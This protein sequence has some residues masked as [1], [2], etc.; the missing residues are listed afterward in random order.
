MAPRAKTA[1]GVGEAIGGKVSF[2]EARISS[3]RIGKHIIRRP[4]VSIYRGAAGADAGADAGVIGGEIF[5]RFTVTL[6]YQSGKR[7]L[8]PNAH[9]NEPY[10]V[11]MSG[12]EL[13]VKANDFKAILIKDVRAGTPAAAAGLREGDVVVSID[14][15]PASEF[16]L[17]KLSKMFRQGGKEYLLT[18]RRDDQVISARL[19]LKRIV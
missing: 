18:V 13:M 3:I 9:F 16:D 10:E 2:T 14:G 6:D 11:D 17:D 4:V 15:R 1:E 5:R 8:K 19:R 12:L 7:L